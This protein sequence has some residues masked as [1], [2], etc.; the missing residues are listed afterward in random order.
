VFKAYSTKT[1]PKQ[2]VQTSN[3]PQNY[4]IRFDSWPLGIDSNEPL[5]LNLVLASGVF[6]RV[7]R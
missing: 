7:L 1:A 6:V 4:L 5:S 3:N 2:E